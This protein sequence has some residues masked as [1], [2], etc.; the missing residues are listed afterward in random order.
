MTTVAFDGKILAYDSQQT[1]EGDYQSS[2]LHVDKGAIIETA[3]GPALFVCV[4]DY[5][6]AKDALI[7]IAAGRTPLLS[8]TSVDILAVL[9]GQLYH[10]GPG[11]RHPKTRSEATRLKNARYVPARAWPVLS[12]S[13]WGSGGYAAEQAMKAFG[14]SASTAVSYACAIDLYSSGEVHAWDVAAFKKIPVKQGTPRL[15]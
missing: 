15:V 7:D 2:K 1:T 10:I 14:A 8:L 13:A 11:H 9:N 6:E 5:W 3:A 12:A 4:G